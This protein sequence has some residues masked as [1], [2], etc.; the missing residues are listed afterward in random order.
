MSFMRAVQAIQQPGL[1]PIHS[2]ESGLNEGCL[3]LFQET[4]LRINPP[5]YDDS[6]IPMYQYLFHDC[7]VL[8]AM[9]GFAPEPYHLAIQR[10][11]AF[12]Y[13]SIPGGVMRGDGLLLDMDTPNWAEWKEPIEDHDQAMRM[14]RSCNEMRRKM[15]NFLISGQMERPLKVFGSNRHRW[16]DPRGRA[17][18][19]ATV[20]HVVW[21][22]EE[23]HLA[24]AITGAAR[25]R[26]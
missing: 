11:S 15:A 12:I 19:L 20:F 21:S 6:D 24:V 3:A 14:I 4:E 10:A 26:P 23:G 7:V 18:N 17:Q 13:G 9:M 1:E 16:I 8:H 22:D 25:C 5:E 2:A